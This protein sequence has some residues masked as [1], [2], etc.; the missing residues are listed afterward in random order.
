[1]SHARRHN[2]WGDAQHIPQRAAIFALIEVGG[3]VACEEWL[4]K[5]WTVV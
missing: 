1:M 2:S 3:A 4:D 5:A